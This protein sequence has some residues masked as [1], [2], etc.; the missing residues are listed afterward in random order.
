MW[1][2]ENAV[3]MFKTCLIDVAQDDLLNGVVLQHL[4]HDTTIATADD[5]N[6]LWVRV[7]GKWEVGNHLLVGE[8]I[9]LG[10]LDN[11]IEHEYI[12][13]CL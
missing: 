5:K 10:A 4:A 1:T 11:T 12:A 9:A 3:E 6:L 2:R 13:V 8:F 7:T